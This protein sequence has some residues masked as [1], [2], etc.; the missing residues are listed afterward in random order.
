MRKKYLLIIFILVLFI[1]VIG[2]S[3]S[4]QDNTNQSN[5]SNLVDNNQNPATTNN[6]QK[7]DNN[8]IQVVK[9]DAFIIEYPTPKSVIGKSF[10]I[11]G[12]AHG[13]FE[14]EFNYELED[15]H[16]MLS[17]GNIMLEGMKSPA[18]WTPFK[19]KVTLDENPTSPVGTLI[20]FDI[21]AKDG[22]RINELI[23][24]FPFDTSIISLK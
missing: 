17:K 4:G 3:M 15:G 16:K 8:Q 6:D 9:N 10:T 2:C 14:G 1:T 22:S 23:I 12:K 13:I 18:D 7:V 20:L 5:A 21:S 24:S 11:I 19:H